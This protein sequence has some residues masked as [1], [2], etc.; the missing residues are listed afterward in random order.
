MKNSLNWD[1]SEWMESVQLWTNQNLSKYGLEPIGN[2][3]KV[4]GWA[5]GQIFKQ[6]TNDGF[7]F[8]KATAFLPL[9]SNESKLCSKLSELV[10]EYV[11]ETI[12]SSS[13]KQWMISKDFGGGLP[14]YADKSLWAKAFQRL[15]NLQQ[16]S[17]KH[18]NELIISGCLRR[19]ITDIPKQLNEILNDS[20]ITQYLPD[21]FRLKKEELVF[22]V[23]QS[24]EE[25]EN[26]NIPSTIVHGDLHIENIAQIND[27]FLFFDWSDACISHPFID[28]TYIFRMP[29]SEDKETI[30]KAYLSQWSD[31][32][33]FETLQ[34]AWN[35]AEL[36]CYA[37]QAI[38][39]ASMKKTLTNEQMKDLEQAFL[40]AFNRILPE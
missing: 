21:E 32:A 31:L 1:S 10:P 19:Q 6:N 30:V 39:Y 35:T 20:N 24:I 7:Y 16:Q 26:F 25:L 5:L 34:K 12:C 29:E 23:K 28:G 33:D 3:Q 13:D 2:L 37:H 22:K 14:E 11:P 36:I 8:F 40:N 27:D 9:F 17:I 4:S 38:S 18:I 15:A